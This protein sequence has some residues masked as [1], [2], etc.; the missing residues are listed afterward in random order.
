MSV[1]LGLIFSLFTALVVIAGDVLIKQ[2]ADRALLASAPM[3]LGIVL[4]AV[5]AVCWFYAMRHVSLGQAAVAYSMLT[6]VALC[7][8][9]AV[10]F[11]EPMGLREVA[12]LTCALAAMALMTHA[13]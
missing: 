4:Y 2:A 3:V 5:S 6:L 13:V 12:G 7:L 1:A 9:G 8:I 11:N 10:A